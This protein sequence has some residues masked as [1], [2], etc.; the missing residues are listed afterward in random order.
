LETQWYPK[1]SH[2]VIFQIETT[3][4]TNVGKLPK[5]IFGVRSTLPLGKFDWFE[6]EKLSKLAQHPPDL[7]SSSP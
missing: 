7:N 4:A 6:V 1:S 5:D 2:E 3:A